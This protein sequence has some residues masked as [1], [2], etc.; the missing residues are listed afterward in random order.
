MKAVL[1]QSRYDTIA[2]VSS[3]GFLKFAFVKDVGDILLSIP[4][5]DY[6]WIEK[7][8]HNRGGVILQHFCKMMV[9]SWRRLCWEF[10]GKFWS[11]FV[12]VWHNRGCVIMTCFWKL[13]PY[14]GSPYPPRLFDEFLNDLDHYWPMKWHFLTQGRFWSGQIIFWSVWAPRLS[15]GSKV[16]CASSLHCVRGFMYVPGSL[17]SREEPEWLQLRSC[18]L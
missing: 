3:W 14:S 5:E 12:Q 13:T 4:D 11:P 17:E 6:S 18:T 7:K 8:W 9:D 2:V 16:L 1:N 10:S 15:V